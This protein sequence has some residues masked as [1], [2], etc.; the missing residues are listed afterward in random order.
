MLFKFIFR[1]S[2]PLLLLCTLGIG[3]ALIVPNPVKPCTIN[4][5]L[6]AGAYQYMTIV[7]YCSDSPIS[8]LLVSGREH[9]PILIK[10]MFLTNPQ[11]S[12]FEE[13]FAYVVR[14][15]WGRLIIYRYYEYDMQSGKIRYLYRSPKLYGA[16]WTAPS[17]VL[18]V[19]FDSNAMCY[20]YYE[21]DEKRLEKTNI[22]SV[23]DVTQCAPTGCVDIST[24][25][26][27]CHSNATP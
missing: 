13:K 16:V 22:E 4:S 26:N 11:L 3:I 21:I 17:S 14:S 9:D 23:P 27:I 5:F 20:Q 18:F 19:N 2:C 8:S 12:A 15:Q 24:R 7:N 1:I 10:G 25:T 6:D